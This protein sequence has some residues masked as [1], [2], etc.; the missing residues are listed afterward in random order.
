MFVRMKDHEVI[1]IL[2]IDFIDGTAKDV[3]DILKSGG[4]LVV[5]AAPALINIK[6]DPAYYN[7]LLFIRFQRVRAG[8]RSR[9]NSRTANGRR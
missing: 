5:P 3:V 1:K 9:K 4:L 2:G 6:K 8:G 7:A